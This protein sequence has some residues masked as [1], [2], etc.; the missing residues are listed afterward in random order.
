MY[1]HR[2]VGL[3]AKAKR[4]NLPLGL[5]LNLSEGRPLSPRD[6]VPSLVDEDGRLLGKAGLWAA[7]ADGAVRPS[8]VAREAN[9]QLR[10]FA[11]LVGRSPT[12]VDGHQHAH[13]A[14]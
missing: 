8:D 3:V 10:Q 13:V 6:E 11:L 9:V 2:Q 12:H 14:P 1:G 7:C 4:A 5:H